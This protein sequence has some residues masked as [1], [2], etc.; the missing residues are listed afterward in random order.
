M[1]MKISLFW[2]STEIKKYIKTKNKIMVKKIIIFLLFCSFI[3][4]KSH[5]KTE[6]IIYSLPH[7]VETK[8]ET[9]IRDKKNIYFNLS[10]IDNKYCI[11]YSEFKN[12]KD[13]HFVKNTNR[14]ILIRDKLYPLVFDYDEKFGTTSTLDE[15]MKYIKENRNPLLKR[16]YNLFD[17]K[18]LIFDLSGYSEWSNNIH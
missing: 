17:G 9:E 14:I 8:I 1:V 10:F 13:D 12:I 15:I 5:L 18:F 4:C 2:R 7:Y 3:S 6:K 11:Y 16:E